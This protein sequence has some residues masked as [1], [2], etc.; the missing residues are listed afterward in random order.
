VPARI[1]ALAL[2]S[3]WARSATHSQIASALDA[4][5]H[6]GRAGD[7][8]RVLRQVAVPRRGPDGIVGLV[9]AIEFDD[10]GGHLV[11]EGGPALDRRLAG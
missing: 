11:R 1:E 10:D 3:G 2:A 5:V 8:R 4:V 7:G 6:L 9:P